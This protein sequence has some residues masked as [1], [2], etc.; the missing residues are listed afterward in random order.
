MHEMAVTEDIL[1]IVKT[2]A[3]RGGATKVSDV[4]LVIGELSSF[5]D[6]SIQFYFDLLTPD[7]IAEG[8]RLHFERIKT[9]FRCRACGQEFEPQEQDWRCPSCQALGG[10]VI[11]GKEF[12]VDSIEV[13]S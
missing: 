8:A 9:R 4:Y 2:H 3:A 12:Y 7:T 1:R 11:A 10:D 5:I 6:D 13:E